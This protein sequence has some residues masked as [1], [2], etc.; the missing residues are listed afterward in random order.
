[1]H[2]IRFLPVDADTVGCF[3]SNARNDCRS[4]SDGRMTG[5]PEVTSDSTLKTGANSTGF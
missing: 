3:G 5:K 4:F 2:S 1:L